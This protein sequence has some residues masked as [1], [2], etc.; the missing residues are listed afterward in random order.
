VGSA[1]VGEFG[2]DGF[3][4]AADIGRSMDLPILGVVDRIW[5]PAEIRAR[6]FRRA[7]VGISSLV[8]I[9]ALFAFTWA[10]ALNPER[11]PVE[12]LETLEGLRLSLR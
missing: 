3:R 9:C 7:I 2:T 10:F 12:W 5:A 1:V 6:F 8:V 11:L 4:T